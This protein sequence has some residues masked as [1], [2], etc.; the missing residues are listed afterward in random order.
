MNEH[1][2]HSLEIAGFLGGFEQAKHVIADINFKAWQD[3]ATNPADLT[4]RMTPDPATMARLLNADG[5]LIHAEA[6][7]FA[8]AAHMPRPDAQAAVKRLC[9]EVEDTGTSLPDLA[10]RDWPGTNW[11]QTLAQHGLGQAP[12]EAR[13]FAQACRA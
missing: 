10:Q 13:A 1:F 5:G 3:V 4:A 11:A 9:R 2:V 6:L 7:S 8:L 12:A